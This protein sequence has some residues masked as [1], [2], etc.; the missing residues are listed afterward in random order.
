[1]SKDFVNEELT[2]KKGDIIWGAV[3][4]VVSL[5]LL[6]PAS[7]EEFVRLTVNYPYP[8]SFLKFAVLATMGEILAVRI[9][10]GSWS[11]PKG[12]LAKAGI[13][14]VLGVLIGLMFGVFNGGAKAGIEMGLLPGAGGPLGIFLA[15]LYTSTMMNVTFGPMMMGAH[16]ISDTYV[17][18]KI[19][20]VEK[21]DL[22]GAIEAV[23]WVGFI[24]FA[25]LKTIPY[26]W[27]PA[28]TLV[29]L[30]P[31]EYRV[32]ASAY[33]SIVLG[34]MM[35]YIKRQAQLKVLPVPVLSA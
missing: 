10:S 23:D 4:V 12:V 32:L 24:K 17:D 1:M 22:M 35:A 33:L 31:P 27:I 34:A 7:R 26:F 28:H 25:V 20:R 6:F 15:A 21:A 3:L 16:R 2:M 29:F 13:W 19:D 5:G 9:L 14:G 30:L 18:R 11:R 8:M